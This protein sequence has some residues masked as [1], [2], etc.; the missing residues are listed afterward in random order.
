MT[1]MSVLLLPRWRDR[2]SNDVLFGRPFGGMAT[3]V[4]KSLVNQVTCVLEEETV[5][6]F[7]IG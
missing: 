5:Y 7:E 4:K 1:I 6:Y 2:L 3:L